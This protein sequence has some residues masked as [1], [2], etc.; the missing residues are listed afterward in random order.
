MKRIWQTEEEPRTDKKFWIR[1][2]QVEK[3]NHEF[4]EI[5]EVRV[6]TDKEMTTERLWSIGR[7]KN[8]KAVREGIK[9]EISDYFLTQ[10]NLGTQLVNPIKE[11][12]AVQIQYI[13]DPEGTYQII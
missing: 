12:C 8:W 4:S 13:N 2:I 1:G 6:Y 10:T 9:R 3:I 11:I 5:L 7:A